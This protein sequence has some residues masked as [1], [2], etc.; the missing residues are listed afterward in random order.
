MT[1]LIK[2]V[3]F[4]E[5]QKIL[6]TKLNTILFFYYALVSFCEWIAFKNG[7]NNKNMRKENFLIKLKRFSVLFYFS[8]SR[9]KNA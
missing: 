5:Q 7:N 8:L 1:C 9:T 4:S 6:E 2:R 3:S